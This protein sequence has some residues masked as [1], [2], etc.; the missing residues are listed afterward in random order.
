MGE[1]VVFKSIMDGRNLRQ[2]P[3][4]ETAIRHYRHDL[5]PDLRLA[6]FMYPCGIGDEGSRGSSNA[7]YVVATLAGTKRLS[8]QNMN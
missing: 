7:S 5:T 6:W 4:H 2:G 8:C 3:D 1:I